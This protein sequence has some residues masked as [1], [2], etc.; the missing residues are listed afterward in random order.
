MAAAHPEVLQ[1]AAI[2]VHHAKWQERPLLIVVRRA[3]STLD[4]DT[5]LAFMRARTARWW[6]P[7]DVQFIDQMPVTGTGKVWKLK[8]REQFKDYVLPEAAAPQR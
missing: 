2:G 8:L 5:L 4:R 1:A 6:V 3:G 7:D